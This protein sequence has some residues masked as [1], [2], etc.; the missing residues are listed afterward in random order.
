MKDIK[1]KVAILTS[2]FCFGLIPIFGT[3]LSTNGISSF[4][5]TFF[6]EIL[7]F[8]IIFPA[9]MIFFKS[10]IIEKKDL[11]FFAL[12][13]LILFSV[14]MFPL[15][16]I[17]IGTPVAFVSLV[18]YMHPVFTLF[19][20][21]FW[22]KEYISRKKLL[23]L[24]LSLIGVGLILN[25]GLQLELITTGGIILAVFS[26]LSMSLWSNF[27]KEA[28]I[29][30]Y[31]PFDTFFYSAAGAVILLIISSFI[32]PHIFPSESVGYF[33]FNISLNN[34]LLLIGLSFTSTVVGHTMFFYGIEKVS[35][36][37]GSILGLIEP[38]TAIVLSAILFNQNI[39]PIMV[40]GGILILTMSVLM[41]IEN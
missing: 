12:F 7:S 24:F 2:A 25:E 8:L 26:A 18:L 28:S 13:G 21:K 3:V 34:L 39:T 20:G 37:T 9:Y 1:N 31:K 33:T 36:V 27:G 11:L 32:F 41:S 10:K 22:F 30:K 35:V 17:A 38:L 4:Q 40:L 14:N 19:V 16:A 15:T 29:R 5:Q 6:M 23:F